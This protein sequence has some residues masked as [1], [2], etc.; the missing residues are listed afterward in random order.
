MEGDNVK[1]KDQ[2]ADLMKKA[3]L[4]KNDASIQKRSLFRTLGSKKD[5]KKSE[6]LYNS[7]TGTNDIDEK[8]SDARN[9][10]RTFPKLPTMKMTKKFWGG[11]AKMKA[12]DEFHNSSNDD[13]PRSTAAS[14]QNDS[15]VGRQTI[16]KS[17]EVMSTLKGRMTAMY[18]ANT[19]R[20]SITDDMQP[21]TTNGTNASVPGNGTKDK[22]SRL[23]PER[24]A[25]E[26][27]NLDALPE[28]PLPIGWEAKLSRSSGRVYY[29]NRKL[30]KSQFERP[31]IASLKAQRLA[32]QK[33]AMEQETT[34]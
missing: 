8:D 13:S 14:S 20:S 1:L 19:R 10:E 33:T 16:V 34:D 17:M 28:Q 12:E 18:N 11:S 7:L 21:V 5:D 31:T 2:V 6:I 22:M 25:H 30:G 29:V 4:N 26:S 24:K 3:G 9:G 15:A 23:K 27:F 32:R